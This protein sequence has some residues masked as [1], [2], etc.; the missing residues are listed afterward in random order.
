M[1]LHWQKLRAEQIEIRC[2]VCDHQIA[3]PGDPYCEHT[4]FVYVD[5]S[6]DDSFF[7]FIHPDMTKQLGQNFRKST[8]LRR[9]MIKNLGL[10]Y[11]CQ[12]HDVTESSG[13][14]PTRVVVGFIDTEL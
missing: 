7:D 10:P 12:V 4:L 9:S 14:Y 5:P 8:K 3:P 1:K 11:T 13:Q 6:T 2:P